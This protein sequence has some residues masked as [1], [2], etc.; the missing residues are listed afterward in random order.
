MALNRTAL[1]SGQQHELIVEC[2][3]HGLPTVD[4]CCSSSNNHA[5]RYRSGS[6]KQKAGVQNVCH[7]DARKGLV[8][9]Q[10]NV[11]DPMRC[12]N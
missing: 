5:Y 1:V 3:C 2:C 6:R 7:L 12:N 4:G 8:P 9:Q 11:I 10:R